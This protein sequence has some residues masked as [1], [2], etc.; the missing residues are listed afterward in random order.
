MDIKR[1][2]WALMAVSALTLGACSKGGGD[3]NGPPPPPPQNGGG[4]DNTVPD[5]QPEPPATPAYSDIPQT[6]EEAA[7]VLTQARSE[8]HTSE[9]HSREN[10]VCS[11]LLA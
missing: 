6:D 8:E 4:G 7:R 9:L 5:P 11:L 10:L 1:L 2:C 3:G